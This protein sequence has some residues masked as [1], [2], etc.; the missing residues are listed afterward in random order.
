M[1][2]SLK[3]WSHSWRPGLWWSHS[4][5]KI[6]ASEIIGCH[7]GNLEEG[8]RGG[9]A[10]EGQQFQFDDSR[11]TFFYFLTFF[12]GLIMT[13]ATYYLWSRDENAEQNRLKN[14]RKVYGRCMWYCLWLLKPQPNI[15]PTVNKIVFL[16]GWALF[17]FLAYKVSKTD[18]EYQE[19]NPY[20][21][22]NLDPRATVA[23]IKKQYCLLSLKYHPDKGSDEVMFMIIAKAYELLTD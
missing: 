6:G 11:N 15:I 18:R 5:E 3:G 21:V 23:E 7:L 8:G 9:G 13:S 19:C 16:A 17:L 22:L 10:M 2:N 12:V 4:F 1:K 14:I 20:E